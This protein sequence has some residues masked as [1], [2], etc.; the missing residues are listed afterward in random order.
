MLKNEK[1]REWLMN[2]KN[3]D[4]L[5]LSG[6]LRVT[7]LNMMVMAWIVP[8]GISQKPRTPGLPG[9]PKM[10]VTRVG[11]HATKYPQNRR[12]TFSNLLGFFFGTSTVGHCSFRMGISKM[13][14]SRQPK[15][16]LFRLVV[17]HISE[18]A[19]HWGSSCPIVVE[20]CFFFLKKIKP[21]IRLL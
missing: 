1:D 6:W 15:P 2:Y 13:V 14:E 12:E 11:C 5:F 3:G 4:L 17:S 19:R 20:T 7:R 16:F 21:S 9:V 8:S 18:Y 10:F